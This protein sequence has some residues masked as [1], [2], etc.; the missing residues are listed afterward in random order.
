MIGCGGS[1]KLTPA[2]ALLGRDL[3]MWS[4]EVRNEAM[5]QP[6][7]RSSVHVNTP[8]CLMLHLKRL[9]VFNISAPP[10]PQRGLEIANQPDF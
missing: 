5:S 7:S 2:V 4:N 1:C 3:E 10:T 9:L 8:R 6:H